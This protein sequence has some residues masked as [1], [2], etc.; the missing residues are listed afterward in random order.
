V[1]LAR[2]RIVLFP[3]RRR[4]AIAIA[5]I[6]LVGIA[7]AL[8]CERLGIALGWTFIP[9]LLIGVLSEAFI[10]TLTD[11]L[12]GDRRFRL[13]SLIAAIDGNAEA[14]NTLATRHHYNDQEVN[15]LGRMGKSQLAHFICA[16]HKRHQTARS[17]YADT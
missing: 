17:G 9:T 7:S 5:L 4:F 14:I 2:F 16:A 12:G 3:L 8:L 11:V 13:L 6:L 1:S 10:H 15:L